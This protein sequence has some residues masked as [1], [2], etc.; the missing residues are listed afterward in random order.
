MFSMQTQNV[1]KLSTTVLQKKQD[2]LTTHEQEYHAR[3]PYPPLPVFPSVTV[4]VQTTAL[5]ALYQRT[6]SECCS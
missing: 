4:A 2:V 1:I 5:A 6:V 3:V